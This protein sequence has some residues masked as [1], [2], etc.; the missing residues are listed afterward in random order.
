VTAPTVSIVIAAYNA[1]RTLPPLLRACADQ[2][3]PH[4][5]EV[6]VVDDG[7]T[8]DTRRLAAEAGVR[9]ITQANRGP[10]A[11][12]NR[13]WREARAAVILFTDADCVP[14]RDWARLLAG[15]IDDRGPVAG[16]SY[17]IANPGNLLAET[18][19]AEIRWRHSRL[20]DEVEYVGSFNLGATRQA[21]ESVGGFDEAYPAASGEDNDLSYRLRKAG[22]R[23]R[24]VPAA[25]V[26]HHHATSLARYLREQSRHGTFRVML[27]AA[28]PEQLRGDGYAG[29]LDFASPPLALLSLFAAVLSPLS[30][31]AAVVSLLSFSSVLF[32][33]TLLALRVALHAGTSTPLSLAGIGS[34]RA[35]ARGWGMAKG[36]VRLIGRKRDGR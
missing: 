6:V 30:A 34:L 8:D 10:A 21:L 5:L 12:R 18:I 35:Y 29:P 4:P 13:G 2:D 19:H 36:I 3:F 25:L 27:Y 28:H 11:A 33:N 26:D 1:A 20:P 16:G 9:V 32:L 14:H 24:F 7:S 23:I 15:A 17:G 31:G 22:H